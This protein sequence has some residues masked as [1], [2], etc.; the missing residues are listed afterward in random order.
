MQFQPIMDGI[1]Q[2]SWYFPCITEI[3]S[4]EA[5]CEKKINLYIFTKQYRKTKKKNN[6]RNKKEKQSTTTYT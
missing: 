4:Y 3:F 6:K 5:P 2:S 1:N